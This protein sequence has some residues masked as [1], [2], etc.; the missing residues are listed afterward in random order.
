M[1]GYGFRFGVLAHLLGWI[2]NAVM[3]SKL[4]HLLLSFRKYIA[5]RRCGL[6]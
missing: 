1:E 5:L 6:S 3:D 2:W 4:I